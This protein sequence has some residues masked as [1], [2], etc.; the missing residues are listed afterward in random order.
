MNFI[1]LIAVD[2]KDSELFINAEHISCI[3]GDDNSPTEVLVNNSITYV[4]AD[5]VESIF[6]KINSNSIVVFPMPQ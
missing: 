5:T 6:N 4:V 1:K 3:Q 2:S